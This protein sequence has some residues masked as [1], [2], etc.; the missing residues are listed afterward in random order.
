VAALR[1]ALIYQ[2]FLDGIEPSERTYHA[3]DPVHWLE[4]AAA[5]A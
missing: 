4:R 3:G 5:I 2:V 1:Q